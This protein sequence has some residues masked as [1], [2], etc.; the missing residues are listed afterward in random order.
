MAPPRAQRFVNPAQW[1]R[2]KELFA[3]A[4]EL[5]I[6][7][8]D[9]YLRG[10]CE[11][12]EEVRVEVAS[13]LAAADGSE[14]LPSARSAVAS[15]ALHSV[16]EKAL[17]QQYEIIRPLG[18]GGMGA[19]YLARE[20]ALERFV[21]IKILR[22]DLATVEAH[23]ERF[24][25]EAR[26]AAQLSHPGIVALHTF[27]EIGGVWYFVM[28]YVRGASLA[29]R[30]RVEGRIPPAEAQRILA[31]L[32]D[33]L[34]CA[35]QSGV[36]HRDIKPAN[37]LL[38]D[39]THRAVLADFG[40]ARMAGAD[41]RLTATGA[42][43][44]T[45]S[46][47]SP[48]QAVGSHDVDERTDIYSFG[49]VAY[50]MLAGREP[51]VAQVVDGRL[52]QRT[53][54]PPT[55]LATI[56]PA[57]PAELSAVI[58]RCLARD[59]GLRWPS[60]KALKEA[61][62]RA[63]G[64]PSAEDSESLR[65]LPSFGPYAVAWAMVW[66]AI[67]A[68]PYRSLLDRAL[69]MLVA[70]IVPT[71]LLMHVFNVSDT[72]MRKSELA[73]VAFWPPQW[74]SM[75]WPTSLRRPTDL[76]H[77]LP[78]TPRATRIILSLFIVAL[79]GT[80]LARRWI[81]AKATTPGCC[82]D[83]VDIAVMW[84]LAG[85]AVV[86][87]A[88]FG[89]ALKRGLSMSEAVRVLLGTTAPSPGWTAP[90][91]ARVLK[92]SA[93]QMHA[94]ERDS[95]VDHRRAINEVLGSLRDVSPAIVNEIRQTVNEAL[96]RVDAMDSEL[97]SLSGA[98]SGSELDRLSAQLSGLDS[99]KGERGELAELVRKQLEVV[100]RMH[101]RAELLAQRRGHVFGL[102]RGLWLQLRAVSEGA[103]PRA[104]DRALALRAELERVEP[105]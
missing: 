64:E 65:E 55:P 69:L 63:A 79:P 90:A 34:E 59:P 67:A 92:S 8:R 30:L 16:L 5:P 42:V 45:P 51:F 75:W 20:K 73:R 87:A 2:V 9:A 29:E 57:T 36:I 10:A 28:R 86:L 81:D 96:R 104:L 23:R 74:W 60:A 54:G 68:A 70:L 41:E 77:R 58:M 18:Q 12:N 84:L 100:R 101:V 47:M 25:R 40:I 88:A 53:A 15:V 85:I 33:A 43:I 35:H 17:G 21:A 50:T 102:L 38:D 37:V 1:E 99:A 94:P 27:G 46:Y 13:L 95:T 26:I 52:V 56:A 61:L 24:R 82:G 80:V 89:W 49:A 19:V 39:D 83:S 97:A 7:D 31:E 78:F 32:A 105:A 93:G 4:V 22:P 48:E 103:D 14:S 98:S 62:A 11:G 71:G 6:A 76:W 3:E 44:G 66:T 91:V 72:G